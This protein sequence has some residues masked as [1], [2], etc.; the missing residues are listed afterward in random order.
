[1]HESVDV[2]KKK[3]ARAD[4][5]RNLIPLLFVL[6]LC[7]AGLMSACGGP[8]TTTPANAGS[9]QGGSNGQ[10]RV[11]ALTPQ[12]SLRV[13]YNAVITVT[14]GSAPYSFSIASGTLPPGLSLNPTT[15]SVT[16]TPTVAGTYNFVISVRSSRSVEYSAPRVPVITPVS[17][18]ASDGEYGSASE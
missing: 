4:A 17:S 11:S 2:N 13:A 10:L 8:M 15:G 18:P 6:A 3:A 7:A 5:T 1:M 9:T 14:G 16:G 12:A